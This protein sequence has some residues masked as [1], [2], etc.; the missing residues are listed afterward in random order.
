M[1]SRGPT[2]GAALLVAALLCVGCSRAAAAGHLAPGATLPPAEQ[3]LTVAV[4]SD[5]PTLD[6]ALAQDTESISAIQL[7]YETLFTY[8]PS[9]QLRG[10]LAAGWQWN[11]SGT[12]LTVELNQA[13]RFAD[14][15]PVTSADVAFS[16]DRLIA[17]TTG[18][19]YALSFSALDGFAQL[20]AGKPWMA[21][22]IQTLGNGEVVFNLQYPV[23]YLPELLAMPC[24]SVVERSLAQGVPAGSNWWFAHSAGSG[25][26][27][28]QSYSPGSDLALRPA[29]AYWRAG[30][31]VGGDPEGPF[32][33]V[34]F[35]II[36][37]PAQQVH[38]FATGSLDVLSAVSPGLL[39]PRPAGSRLWQASDLGL[40]YLG[41]NV[42]KPPF[43]NVMMRQAVAYAVN[44]EQLL[45][46]GGGQG[47]VAGG[48]LP[49]GIAGYN[50]A[51]APHPYDPGKARALFAAAGGTPGEPVQLLTIAATGTVQQ[52]GT[53][54]V[55][56]AVAQDLDA[57]GFQVTLVQESWTAYYRD[58]A[59][60]RDNLF[61]AQWLADYPDPEDF[62]FNLLDSAAI[63]A[64]NGSRYTSAAFDAAEAAAAA[65]QAPSA[66]AA[67]YSRLD[68]EVAL[69]LPLLPE[70]YTRSAVLTQSWVAPDLGAIYGSAPLQPQ[71]DRVWILPHS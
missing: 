51:I 53:D 32:V 22:G 36:P 66:R 64:G 19:P 68:Q 17:S 7:M 58:L 26:Y 56:A 21:T 2:L 25:P 35:R 23:P 47:T 57:I 54:A 1:G 33:S 48:L 42:S 31:D 62:M 34:D 30:A 6:P 69:A 12:Q 37:S 14:G 18:S 38:L 41:F 10:R 43:N 71:Y 4:S 8:G 5:F 46:A 3:T 67:A 24:T 44:V 27:V 9:G 13:A 39:G 65:L 50:P 70:Y 40:A 11:A 29:H 61:Q 16:L 59:A 28:F 15:T 55:A 20:R 60:G 49:P 45:A 52:P 63:G